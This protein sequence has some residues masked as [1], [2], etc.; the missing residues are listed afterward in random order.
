MSAEDGQVDVP[1][2]LPVSA[3]DNS[4]SRV[5]PPSRFILGLWSRPKPY[6]PPET[7]TGEILN[8][9]LNHVFSIEFQLLTR[10]GS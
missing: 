1:V 8:V 2:P 9:H 4:D 10:N 6:L 3:A 5:D 7:M